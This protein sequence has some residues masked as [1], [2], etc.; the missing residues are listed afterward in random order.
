MALRRLGMGCLQ[1]QVPGLVVLAVAIGN[2]AAFMVA[3][4]A[5]MLI[6]TGV[7]PAQ[8]RR[9]PAATVSSRRAVAMCWAFQRA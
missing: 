8:C 5:A 9:S 1:R 6:E 4:L 2:D 7:V 3:Q